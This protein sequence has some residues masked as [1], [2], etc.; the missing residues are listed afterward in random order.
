[1]VRFWHFLCYSWASWFE[2]RGE[3]LTLQLQPSLSSYLPNVPEGEP[4]F[5]RAMSACK[6]GIGLGECHAT[7]SLDWSWFYAFPGRPESLIVKLLM[8][9]SHNGDFFHREK[10]TSSRFEVTC[11]TSRMLAHPRTP[12]R[13]EDC[14]I[15]LQEEKTAS[16]DKFGGAWKKHV[17]SLKSSRS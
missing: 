3:V 17:R 13:G 1:M 4:T 5:F 6:H 9:Y 7:C 2:L 16:N 15:V 12:P 14:P 11:T 8:V 10:Q